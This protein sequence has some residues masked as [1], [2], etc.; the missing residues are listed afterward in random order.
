MDCRSIMVEIKSTSNVLDSFKCKEFTHQ[1]MML[2]C[3]YRW[4]GG[5][6]IFHSPILGFIKVKQNIVL[7]VTSRNRYHEV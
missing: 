4:G 5:V 7:A 6:S 1:K 3:V 2:H